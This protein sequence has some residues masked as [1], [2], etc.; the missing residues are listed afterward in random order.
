MSMAFDTSMY[1]WR[2]YK[3][4]YS[5]ENGVVSFRQDTPQHV[6]DSYAKYAA[7]QE[8]MHDFATRNDL[9]KKRKNTGLFSRP[10]A[11]PHA[12]TGAE[13]LFEALRD[14]KS[15]EAA[16]FAASAVRID[17]HGRATVGFSQMDFAGLVYEECIVA[18]QK[19]V[20]IGSKNS[21]PLVSVILTDY[22]KRIIQIQDFTSKAQ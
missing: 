17:E 22:K 12:K 4:Y 1:E 21:D 15:P 18:E 3:A 19:C 20:L 14:K 11:S 2:K 9:K 8:A 7:Q 10:K 13:L 6:L 5:E 16:W